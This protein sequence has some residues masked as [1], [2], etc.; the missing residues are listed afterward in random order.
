MIIST[1]FPEAGLGIISYLFMV[2][3]YSAVYM[4]LSESIRLCFYS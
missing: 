2:E 3:K 4:D 1:F